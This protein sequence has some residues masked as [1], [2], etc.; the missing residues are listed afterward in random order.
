MVSVA[1]VLEII[2]GKEQPHSFVLYVYF[3]WDEMLWN[4]TGNVEIGIL[5]SKEELCER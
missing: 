1:T 4:V 5:D 2:S 3:S